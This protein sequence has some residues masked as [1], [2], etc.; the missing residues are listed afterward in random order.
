M[1]EGSSKKRD[2]ADILPLCAPLPDPADEGTS[3]SFQYEMGQILSSFVKS[4]A[5]A[6]VAEASDHAKQRLP[7]P[8][9]CTG[10]RRIGFTV[11]RSQI[12]TL[13]STYPK[14]L[15]SESARK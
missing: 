14:G 9:A 13:P 12:C 1:L 2:A 8:L 4:S 11:S 6:N 10:I 15:L 7:F 5:E 3:V